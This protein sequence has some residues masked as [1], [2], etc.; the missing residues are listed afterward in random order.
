MK[1]TYTVLQKLGG[2]L[3]LGLSVAGFVMPLSAQ[4]QVHVSIGIG[5]PFPVV[6]VPAPVVVA[7]APVVIERRPVIVQQ[8]FVQPVVVEEYRI[9]GH[10]HGHKFFK[11]WKHD[12]D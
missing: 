1:R 2:L 12:D 11:H 3:F 7:P 5:L 6:I 8:R 10:G 9:H 4:A